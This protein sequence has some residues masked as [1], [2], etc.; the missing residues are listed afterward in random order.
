MLKKYLLYGI[1]GCLL[2][3]TGCNDDEEEVTTPSYADQNWFV[4]PD[5][6]GEFNQ[7]VYN[8]YV[9]TGVPIFVNDTLGEEYYAKDMEGN[10]INRLETF[11]LSYMLF[12]STEDQ[13]DGST[14]YAVQSRDTA[15]MIKA[16]TL[17]RDRVLP[18]L[19][20]VGEGR[21]KCFFLVDS[22]NDTK[23]VQYSYFNPAMTVKIANQP[24]YV[25]T[26]GIV[27]GQLCDINQMTEEEIDLWCGR[28]IA[29]KI[30]SWLMSDAMDLAEWY[31]ITDEGAGSSW[32]KKTIEN[33]YPDY[34]ADIKASAGMFGW[35]IDRPEFR[36]AQTQEQDVLE[37]VTRVCNYQGREQ[38]F[39]DEMAGF[40]KVIRK[41]QLMREYVSIFE[42]TFNTKAN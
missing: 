2:A 19:P 22:L 39:L 26:K 11:N 34:R 31:N 25:A 29:A 42:K 14:M 8:I 24:L 4:I 9:E 5:K 6:P 1:C 40:D 23:I 30:T 7:L 3:F 38:E 13:V 12:G 27:V 15:A 21:P 28:V 33:W 32:Y 10:V 35:Y 17:L 41:F 20:K 37:Y 16:A 18:K 36:M